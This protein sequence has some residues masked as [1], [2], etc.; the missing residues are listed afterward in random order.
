M[1]PSAIQWN[2]RSIRHKKHEICFLIN[3]Y[4]PSILAISETWLRPGSRFRVPGYSCLRDDSDNGWDGCALL[5]KNPLSYSSIPLP[6]H[7]LGLNIVAARALD[8]TFVSLYI[9]HP[10]SS[11]ILE[12]DSILSSLSGPLVVMGDFNCHHTLWGSHF[13]DPYSP[14]V[15]NMLDNYNLCLMN[16][17]S[18]T[19]RTF[20]SQNPSSVDRTL[21]S[22]SLAS[23]L[24]WSV[25]SRSHGS[26]H[27]PILLTFSSVTPISPTSLPPLLKY[28][29][30]NADWDEFSLLVENEVKLLPPISR[31]NFLE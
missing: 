20:P 12:V 3:K 29:L 30:D 1:A 16:D 8:F 6:Q 24:E 4:K 22:S 18:P 28:R 14:R 23:R 15:L 10:N 17:G 26:D 31:E 5:V 27:L 2:C 11:Y 7:S 9:P 19:R 25:L 13:C 21:V